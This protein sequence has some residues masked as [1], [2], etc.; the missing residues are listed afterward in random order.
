MSTV[1][2][3]RAGEGGYLISEFARGNVAIGWQAIGDMTS[4]KSQNE[5]REK[6]I[7][8]YPDDKA[9]K[10]G[11][12]AAMA[13]KFC[14]VMQKGDTVISYDPEAREYLVGNIAG[15]YQFKPGLI[16]DYPHIRSVSWVGRVPRD[17]LSVAAKNSLGSTLTLFAVNN[18][19]WAEIETALMGK[20]DI[21]PEPMGDESEVLNNIK[22][23]SKEF[24]KD[25][26]SRLGPFELQD[27]V[28]GLLRAMGYKTRVSLPGSDRGI[29]I[30][31]S[32]D[33]FGFEQP[34]IVVE[35]KHRKGAMGSQD[36][37]SF[38]GGRHK[39]DKGLYVSTGGFTKE[40]RY[41]AD[42]A[43]IPLTLMDMDQLV[44]AITDNYEQMDSQV[45]TL[46]PLVKAYLPA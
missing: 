1:W 13:Y 39:D 45:R 14:R 40:A 29:D 35:C 9:G 28:A 16:G 26:I 43:S 38:L 42:R 6:Y 41:E 37:R 4:I 19:V 34:R 7:S 27:L 18:D 10:V 36:V 24:I 11:N 31:A 25:R 33:G 21:E 32:P 23:Q 46:L 8:A 22:E 3:V 17:A 15:D 20:K 5:M 44:D 12:A 30:L 2:M